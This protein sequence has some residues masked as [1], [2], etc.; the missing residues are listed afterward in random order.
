MRS[1]PTGRPGGCR[2]NIF[3]LRN[4]VEGICTRLGCSSGNFGVTMQGDRSHL[5]FQINA[6]LM[7]TQQVNGAHHVT[8]TKGSDNGLDSS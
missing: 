8:T 1:L 4:C 5:N 2:G 6:E 3:V 7:L